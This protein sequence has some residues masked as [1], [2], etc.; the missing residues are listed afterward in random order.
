LFWQFLTKFLAKIK[1]SYQLKD[2][3]K[4]IANEL[5]SMMLSIDHAFAL[6]L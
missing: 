2:E 5:G 4:L 1:I 6:L 3:K